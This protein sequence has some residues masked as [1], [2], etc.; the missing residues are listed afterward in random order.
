MFT[1]AVGLPF[2]LSIR[3]Q[4]KF[5][6]RSRDMNFQFQDLLYYG[7]HK[8]LTYI[9]LKIVCASYIDNSRNNSEIIVTEKGVT[10][11]FRF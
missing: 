8:A 11:R 1:A 9:M 2:T 3:F 10:R 7:K 5:W 6:I 4:I